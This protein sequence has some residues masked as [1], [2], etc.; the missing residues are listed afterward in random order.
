MAPSE[1]RTPSA[2]LASIARSRSAMLLLRRVLILLVP[3]LAFF[4]MLQAL[5]SFSMPPEE[6]HEGKLKQSG[7]SSNHHDHSNKDVF[8]SKDSAITNLLEGLNPH[9]GPDGSS[10]VKTIKKG[11][12]YHLASPSSVWR[13]Q[14][15]TINPEH[16]YT[17]YSPDSA[18]PLLQTRHRVYT[19]VDLQD[20]KTSNKTSD[21]Q[22]ELENAYH[23]ES[24]IVETWK[25]SWYAM[26]FRPIVLTPSDAEKHYTYQK[27][28][29]LTE[30]KP[31]LQGRLLKTYGRWFAF[32]NKDSEGILSD[33]RVLPLSRNFDHPTFAKLRE[34]K[35]QESLSLFK[36]DL[37]LLMCNFN[38]IKNVLDVIAKSF[39]T[40][41]AAVDSEKKAEEKKK[42]KKKILK[43]ADEEDG[44]TTS[45]T[46]SGVTT[47]ITTGVA[48]SIATSITKEVSLP[49]DTGIA[50]SA[51]AGED[52]EE[53]DEDENDR[54]ADAV[55]N[56]DDDKFKRAIEEHTLENLDAS[57]DRLFEI[58]VHA[59]ENPFGDY[60]DANIDA[61]TSG[62]FPKLSGTEKP[63]PSFVL[64][65]INIHLHQTFLAA[66][67]HGIVYV[68]PISGMLGRKVNWKSLDSLTQ[69]HPPISDTGSPSPENIRGLAAPARNIAD[70]LASCPSA[71]T[72]G[73]YLN[74]CPPTPD[75]LGNIE[76][77]NKKFLSKGSGRL[78]IPLKD[79]CTPLPCSEPFKNKNPGSGLGT[80]L[81]D[82]LP[83][84]L[85][86][87]FYAIASLA[88][89]I[90]LLYASMQDASAL[91][92]L[93]F[94]RYHMSR[95]GQTMGLTSR[96]VFDG[97]PHISP[98][99]KTMFL[100]D[101][102]FEYAAKTNVS[103]IPYEGN[104]ATIGQVL[105]WELGF[106]PLRTGSEGERPK[107]YEEII[108]AS[109]KEALGEERF[110]YLKDLLKTTVTEFQQYYREGKRPFGAPVPA[111]VKQTESNQ[112]TTNEERLGLIDSINLWSPND[113]ELW[114]FLRQWTLRKLGDI[115]APQ[116]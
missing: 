90:F 13:R 24:Q 37:S 106:R 12:V 9:R 71:E 108:K 89:P 86:S 72:Y 92:T 40:E 35:F 49:N 102:V 1:L 96:G 7:S 28:F 14:Q 116:M 112:H 45:H 76:L 29:K 55:K 83:D 70:D 105:E 75:T 94:V 53:E 60:S 44:E 10:L 38:G 3:A 51:T 19:Y 98:V 32:A 81:V 77:L 95:D 15:Y 47:G 39:I 64:T 84:P 73:A 25:R 4:F 107:T 59:L 88:H 18:I 66:Y 111:L 30:G 82:H 99:Y 8:R 31:S 50:A 41:A 115:Y 67:P 78:N 34:S 69:V 91:P 61:I 46:E 48:T 85:N 109:Q 97:V 11:L 63:D 80:S 65:M 103:W 101:S 52:E 100:K 58:Y 2:S 113:Y 27:L 54:K 33:H 21:N 79:A 26:G 20:P 56:E 93:D 74:I 114:S 110:E 57:I 68:D 22:E 5:W 23:A 87:Q 6:R 36:S 62:H 16:P 104:P 42:R 43:D 17:R